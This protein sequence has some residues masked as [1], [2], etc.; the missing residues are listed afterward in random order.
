MKIWEAK[1]GI[2]DALRG[3]PLVKQIYQAEL[4]NLRALWPGEQ[5]ILQLD[6]GV[7]TGLTLLALPMARFCVAADHSKKMLTL[8][9]AHKNRLPIQLDVEKLLPFQSSAFDL[10]TAIGLTEYLK[11]IHLFFA[12]VFRVAKPGAHFIVTNTPP[13]MLARLRLFTGSPARL[14]AADEVRNALPRAG[15]LI[16]DYKKSLIQEQW[17]CRKAADHL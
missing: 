10:V 2:Y 13:A 15:W 14:R 9:P 3:L 16:C 11:D 7:G 4:S 6:L 8:L 5:S 17:L 1:A 12:E